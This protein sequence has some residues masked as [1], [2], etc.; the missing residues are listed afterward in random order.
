M[1]I[2]SSQLVIYSSTDCLYSVITGKLILC[3]KQ[4]HI[5]ASE[6]N[7]NDVQVT[8]IIQGLQAP[9]RGFCGLIKPGCSG[10][11]HGDSC[12]TTSASIRQQLGNGLLKIELGEYTLSVLCELTNPN[13]TFEYHV[14]RFPS[15]IMPTFCT[16]KIQNNKVRLRLRKA[17][18]SDQW[19]GALAVTGLDQG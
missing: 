5:E 1:T 7:E 18:G 4:P 3:A 11:F 12:S 19:A 16:Y 13:D 17:Y 8:L 2:S 6:L 9:H 10:N 14:R 15:K